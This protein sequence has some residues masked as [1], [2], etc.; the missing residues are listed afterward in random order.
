MGAAMIA[1]HSRRPW[2]RIPDSGASRC[3]RNNEAE[4]HA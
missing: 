3:L 2:R 1:I 4:K